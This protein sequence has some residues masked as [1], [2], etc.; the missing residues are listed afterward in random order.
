MFA[1]AF[2]FIG[3]DLFEPAGLSRSYFLVGERGI[4]EDGKLF[5]TAVTPK[6][7]HIPHVGRSFSRL[8]L[9]DGY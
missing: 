3:Q 5:S 6:S 7:S 8:P 1:L 2:M 4:V 9:L